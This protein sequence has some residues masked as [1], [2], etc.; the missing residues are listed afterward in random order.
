MAHRLCSFH[1]TKEK[2][3]KFAGK[4]KKEGAKGVKI[5]GKTSKGYPVCSVLMAYPW[6]KI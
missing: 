2:A 6:E 1:K 5:G 3:K 4:L